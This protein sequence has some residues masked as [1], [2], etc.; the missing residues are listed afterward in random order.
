MAIYFITISYFLFLI[1][2]SYYLIKNIFI[3]KDLLKKYP[4][5]YQ[6][7]V[8]S[9]SE[10]FKCLNIFFAKIGKF[11]KKALFKTYLAKLENLISDNNEFKS[12]HF[13]IESFT[14]F[15]IFLSILLF[16]FC[17]ISI[18]NGLFMI[19]SSTAGLIAGFFIPDYLIKH[20]NLKRL[21]KM[22]RDLPYIIDLLYV[23]SLSGQ[24][25]Y[26]SIKTVIQKY[27]SRISNE[28]KGFLQQID[29][30]IG[31]KEAYSNIIR[32][33]NSDSFKSFIFTLQQAE[34]YGSSI[35]ELLRQKAE[36]LRFEINQDIDR[37]TRLISTKMLFPLIFLILPSFL[38]LVCG[39]L[40]YLVGGSM[41]LKS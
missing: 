29:F 23:A 21:Q 41:F 7:D 1:F 14:G 34:S 31:K 33:N 2:A 11:A 16:I 24:N 17:I 27:D 30:G 39:P 35:S 19:I 40:V 37:K 15:K 10:L 18:N 8:S 22:D 13:T 26:N 38:L 6:N 25:I 28:F 5:N 36:F 32:K 20:M 12:S 4:V 3:K 9:K